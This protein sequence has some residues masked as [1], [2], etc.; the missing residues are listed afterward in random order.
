MLMGA[1]ARTS[2]LFCLEKENF[3]RVA[4]LISIRHEVPPEWSSMDGR[5]TWSCGTLAEEGL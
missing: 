2:N 1:L 5:V 4:R 3:F